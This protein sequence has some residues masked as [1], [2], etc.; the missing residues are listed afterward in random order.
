MI[1]T[2][3]TVAGMTCQNCVNHVTEELNE[4]P[5]VTAIDIELGEDGGPS[6]VR[7]ISEDRIADDVLE[8]AIDEAGYEVVS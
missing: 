6:T 7:V 4:I 3:L 8:A 2:K 5:G 1:T